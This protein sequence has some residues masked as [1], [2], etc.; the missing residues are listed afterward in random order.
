MHSGASQQQEGST[1]A[2]LGAKGTSGAW[3]ITATMKQ[4][5]ASRHQSGPRE[6]HEYIGTPSPAPLL[7]S[8]PRQPCSGVG[9]WQGGPGGCQAEGTPA[10]VGNHRT[11][12]EELVLPSTRALAPQGHPLS[13]PR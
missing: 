9:T 11:Q 5:G 2:A 1:S 3:G 6:G 4:L 7:F 8:P 13:G 12:Q 10:H